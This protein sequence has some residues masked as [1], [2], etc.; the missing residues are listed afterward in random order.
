[1]LRFR[2]MA[3]LL[4]A[5]AMTFALAGMARAEYLG[6]VPDESI[7]MLETRRHTCTLIAAGMMV[8]AYAA[9][10]GLD[11]SGFSEEE[12]TGAAWANGLSWDFTV[13]NINV[14]CVQDIREAHDPAQYLILFLRYHPEGLVIYDA[15]KPHAV[16]LAGYDEETDTFLCADTFDERGG[17]LMPL[18]ET[19]LGG[20][21]QQEALNRLDR[22]WYVTGWKGLDL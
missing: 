21:T 4:V 16:W 6:T 10:H 18:A 2:R 1:M 15:D 22:I 8:R 13:Q 11:P 7:F 19:W 5:L 12:L 3:A 9:L 14:Q 20:G 17:R